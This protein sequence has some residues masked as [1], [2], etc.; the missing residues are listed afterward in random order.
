MIE[1]A[2][3]L[4]LDAV[5]ALAAADKMV[6]NSDSCLNVTCKPSKDT[7]YSTAEG[8]ESTFDLQYT[9]KDAEQPMDEILHQSED[10]G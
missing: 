5:L 7:I 8:Q 6:S 9:T 10:T 4:G 2:V 3:L 1:L